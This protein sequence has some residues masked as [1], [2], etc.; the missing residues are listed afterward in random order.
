MA[1][2]PNTTTPPPHSQRAYGPHHAPLHRHAVVV[3]V[4]VV[5]AWVCGARPR[6][7]ASSVQQIRLA[8]EIPTR[9]RSD[10]L[11]LSCLTS[12]SH[13]STHTNTGPGSPLPAFSCGDE[14]WA[15][16]QASSASTR[17]TEAGSPQASLSW[18][19]KQVVRT[20]LARVAAMPM[21]PPLLS[22]CC[23]QAA[24]PPSNLSPLR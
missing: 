2:L 11:G 20:F 18:V 12:A 9:S 16:L 22:L 1:V 13:A 4:A 19:P 6:L 7:R 14:P 21:R 8:F 17:R 10:M 15:H 3:L 23:C 5:L 24:C